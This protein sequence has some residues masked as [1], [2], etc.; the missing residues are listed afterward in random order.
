VALVAPGHQWHVAVRS[1]VIAIR[2]MGKDEVHRLAEL[3][4]LEPEDIHMTKEL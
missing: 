3:L 2:R 4:A 1:N